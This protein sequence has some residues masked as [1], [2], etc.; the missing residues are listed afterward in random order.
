[1]LAF[2]GLVGDRKRTYDFVSRVAN[3]CAVSDRLSYEVY[4][5]NGLV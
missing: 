2:R 4:S 5:V 3:A 1:M